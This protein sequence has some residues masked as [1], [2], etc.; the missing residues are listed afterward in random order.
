MLV[1]ALADITVDGYLVKCVESLCIVCVLCT[2]EVYSLQKV[3]AYIHQETYCPC[4]VS[5]GI[6]VED[7]ARPAL[8]TDH[9]NPDIQGTCSVHHSVRS[10]DMD[11]VC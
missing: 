1:Q 4:L 6:L 8:I 2:L 3:S 9:Q 5:D 7:T 10:S 11:L